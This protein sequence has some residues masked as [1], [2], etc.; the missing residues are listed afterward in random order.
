MAERPWRVRF[1]AIAERDF[2]NF[3]RENRAS[4]S[5]RSFGPHA[6][7]DDDPGGL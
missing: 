6:A 4:M 5:K 2:A 3:A 1:G 7:P